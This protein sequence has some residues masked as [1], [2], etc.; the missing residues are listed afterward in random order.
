MK[1]QFGLTRKIMRL[2]KFVEHLKAAAVATDAKNMD[3]VLRTCAIGRQFGYAA[4]MSFDNLAA[5]SEIVF[6]SWAV[7]GDE[8]C[9]VGDYA[10]VR[11]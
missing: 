2:G 5:V 6:F 8:S 9:A 4:Y 7:G 11:T 3:P 1:K 10:P